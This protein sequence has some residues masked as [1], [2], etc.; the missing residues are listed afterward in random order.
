M[1][2][3]TDP[4]APEKQQKGIEGSCLQAVTFL[5]VASPPP[6]EGAFQLELSSFATLISASDHKV[7]L[8]S[9]V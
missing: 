1:P 8:Y 2:L 4:R 5:T 6:D 3:L 9:K 7:V